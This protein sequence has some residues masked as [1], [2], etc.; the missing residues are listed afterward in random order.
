M[1]RAIKQTKE[2]WVTPDNDTRKP[3]HGEACDQD[4]EEGRNSIQAAGGRVLEQLD[5]CIGGQ[6]EGGAG[7]GV[8]SWH[9]C[10]GCA[11][12]VVRGG[13]Q[14]KPRRAVAS[15]GGARN[16]QRAK[17]AKTPAREGSQSLAK[18]WR[19]L[20]GALLSFR[21]AGGMGRPHRIR[22]R[23]VYL[24]MIQKTYGR[25]A[26][27]GGGSQGQRLSLPAGCQ[28]QSAP[29]APAGCAQSCKPRWNP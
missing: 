18:G 8:C 17:P 16:Q 23:R 15:R 20:A 9:A 29:Q 22:F 6:P 4:R 7:R 14:K 24:K 25:E 21:W 11:R 27:H 12:R 26:A 3:R 2:R 19:A 28:P 5:H 1:E 10:C 13:R